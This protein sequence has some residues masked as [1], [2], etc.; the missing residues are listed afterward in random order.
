VCFTAALWG[1]P[2]ERFVA[3]LYVLAV[4]GSKLLKSA[5]A[6]DFHQVETGVFAV[7]LAL[8][9]ALAAV[10]LRVGRWW[11][12]WVTAFQLIS[13]LGHLARLVDT[14]MTPLAYGLME[15]ASSYP[16]LI[17]LGVGIVQHRRRVRAAAAAGRS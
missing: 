10:T 9:L 8:L 1:G 17:G 3:L 16:A 6:I 7:D 11:L 14:G 12:I 4:A 15:S 2:P 13:T 5:P